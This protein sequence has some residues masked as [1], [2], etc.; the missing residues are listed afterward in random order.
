MRIGV[1]IT[2]V[3]SNIAS[4]SYTRSAQGQADWNLCNTFSYACSLS[5]MFS[6]ADPTVAM[7]M[8]SLRKIKDILKEG[9]YGNNRIILTWLYSAKTSL[10][11]AKR[12]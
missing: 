12:Y 1:L 9:I 11:K 6:I 4:F 7:D 5:F 10:D 2:G 8:D 3:M